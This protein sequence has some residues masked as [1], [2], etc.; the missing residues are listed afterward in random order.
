M[1]SNQIVLEIKNTNDTHSLTLSNFNKQP[2]KQE[3]SQKNKLYT[4]LLV[5]DLLTNIYLPVSLCQDCAIT[6]PRSQPLN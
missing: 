4:I 6:K 5:F 3:V 1:A 2:V